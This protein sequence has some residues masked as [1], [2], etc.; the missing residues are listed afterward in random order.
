MRKIYSLALAL[1]VLANPA[2]AA[3]E[4]AAMTD[5]GPKGPVQIA[6]A[7]SWAD[8]MEF[9]VAKGPA[10]DLYIRISEIDRAAV[11]PSGGAAGGSN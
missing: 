3:G 10:A 11:T 2:F 5:I 9:D 6:P 8:V 4:S 1:S 7:K